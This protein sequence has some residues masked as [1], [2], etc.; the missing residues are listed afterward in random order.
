MTSIRYGARP[1]EERRN[2]EVEAVQRQIWTKAVTVV[3][4][5]DPGAI[6]FEDI[7]LPMN[8]TMQAAFADEGVANEYDLHPGIHSDPYRWPWLREQ[9]E[10]QYAR[11]SHWD[12]SGSAPPVPT[13]FD[14]RTIRTNF[15]VWRWRFDVARQ[16]VE[17]LELLKV[18]R[19]NDPNPFV[20]GNDAYLRYV[21]I[22]MECALAALA[23]NGQ[24]I[25]Q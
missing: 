4:E 18:R 21:D 3:F 7:V 20:I 8:L 1:P 17:F 5:T 9:L 23:R 22:Q 15:S 2:R 11:V 10:A 25:D 24:K 19:G 14:Y 12:G 16:P 13:R 6:A